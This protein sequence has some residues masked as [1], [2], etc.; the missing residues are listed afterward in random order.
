MKRKIEFEVLLEAFDFQGK[1]KLIRFPSSA[2][3]NDR[4]RIPLLT[5]NQDL[6]SRGITI[7][8]PQQQITMISDFASYPTRENGGPKSQMRPE[9]RDS[10][11]KY[12]DSPSG[13]GEVAIRKNIRFHQRVTNDLECDA[14]L[15]GSSAKAVQAYSATTSSYPKDRASA[16]LPK[17][18]MRARAVLVSWDKAT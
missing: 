2:W 6:V 8:Y 3:V 7:D 12:S 16:P 18:T 10:P 13:T 11:T 9:H 1:M 4:E 15:T 14:K 17:T 5:G